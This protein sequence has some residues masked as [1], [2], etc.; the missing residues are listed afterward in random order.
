[1]KPSRLS[2]WDFAELTDDASAENTFFALNRPYAETLILRFF[3]HFNAVKTEE[4]L[5]SI[6][7]NLEIV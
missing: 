6:L 7:S 4:S 5:C 2:V 3:E 1:L